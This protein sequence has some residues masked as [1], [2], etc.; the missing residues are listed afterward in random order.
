MTPAILETNE[1][2]SVEVANNNG[3]LQIE[4]IPAEPQISQEPV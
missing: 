3:I 4:S 1:E 2:E